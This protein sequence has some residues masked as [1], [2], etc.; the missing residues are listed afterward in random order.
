[1]IIFYNTKTGKIV[2]SIEGRVH[3][4]EQLRMN[5]DDEQMKWIR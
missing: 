1:M 4:E 2:G 3:T 5:I